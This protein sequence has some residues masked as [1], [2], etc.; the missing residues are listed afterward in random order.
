MGKCNTIF[1]YSNSLM[2][3]IHYKFTAWYG[4]PFRISMPQHSCSYSD[5]PKQQCIVTIL[6]EMLSYHLGFSF[7]ISTFTVLS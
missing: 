2:H 7:L 4:F 6:D 3:V 5:K 1:G